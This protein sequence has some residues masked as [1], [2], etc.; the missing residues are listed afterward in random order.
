MSSNDR[1]L[2]IKEFTNQISKKVSIY[3]KKKFIHRECF[4]VIWLVLIHIQK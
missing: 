4:V 3:D 2:K 1:T